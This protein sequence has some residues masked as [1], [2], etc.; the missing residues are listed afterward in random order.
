MTLTQNKSTLFTS[1]FSNSSKLYSTLFS[2]VDQISIEK[3][4]EGKKLVVNGEDFMINGMNWDYFPIG[5][6]Y[7]TVYGI[8]RMILL[9][10][11]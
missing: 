2:Q 8:N 10:P 7:S 9:K 3:S 6:N 11:L 4:D 1:Y 5:T